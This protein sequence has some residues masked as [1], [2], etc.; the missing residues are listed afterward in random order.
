MSAIFGLT[1]FEEHPLDQADLEAMDKALTAYGPERGGSTCVNKYVGLGQ[2]LFVATPEDQLEDQP[3]FDATRNYVLVSDARIDN[4]Q[5]LAEELGVVFAKPCP[6][7]TFILAAYER[8]GCDC[9]SHLVGAF[10]FA[11][12]D[13]R[14]SILLIAR[15]QTGERSVYYYQ[16]KSCLA[17]SSAPRGLFALPFVAKR[18]NLKSTA[19]FLTFVS[20]EPGSSF[21]EGV[22]QIP[23]GHA[24]II[25]G[26]RIRLV[27]S[28]PLKLERDICFSRDQDYVDRLNELLSRAIDDQIRS[29]TRVGVSMSG[30]L[31]STSVAAVAAEILGRKGRRLQTYTEIPEP[32]FS[33]DLPQGRYAN[34]KPYVDAVVGKYANIDSFFVHSGKGSYLELLLPFFK[35]ADAPIR[36]A[37]N[38]PWIHAILQRASTDN[39]RILLTG[40]PGNLTVSWDGEDL[41]P[42]LVS[43][44]KT[45]PAALREAKAYARRNPGHTLVRVILSAV[46]RQMPEKFQAFTTLVCAGDPRLAFYPRWKVYSPIR[47]AFAA[48]ERIVERQSEHKLRSRHLSNRQKRAQFLL[49]I[50]DARADARRAKEA[51]YGVRKLDP[52]NDVRIMEFCL[53]IPENQFFYNGESRS[54][55]RR[56]M[57]ERLPRA[58]VNNSLRGL[59]SANWLSSMDRH[60]IE[61]RE[62]MRRL[63][64][65]PLASHV[66]DLDRM[67]GLLA[68]IRNSTAAQLSTVIKFRRVIELGVTM[69]CFLEW[70][71]CGPR[72]RS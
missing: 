47:T 3:V 31:D 36:N 56:A 51:I 20:H 28:C 71:E 14:R 63:K 29:L 62:T 44:P 16:S 46:F 12:Y 10:A 54:L 58:V 53:S 55:I 37:S 30:G 8:W 26:S 49:N 60:Q 59:Q 18:A 15:S 70:I 39:V 43:S 66:I 1:G 6:D 17:F 9:S 13:L 42:N 41:L 50:A 69:G 35:A 4:R 11:L 23:A 25:E 45:W 2:R 34:E 61:L 24:L 7:S 67:D 57:A 64:R 52:L 48:E 27:H 5:E 65:S 40:T 32:D 72:E 68:N 19:N 33:G 21:F 22:Q 38:W